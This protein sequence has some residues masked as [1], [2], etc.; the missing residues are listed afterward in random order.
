MSHCSHN[1]HLLQTFLKITFALLLLQ[2]AAPERD[3]EIDTILL[4]YT[5]LKMQNLLETQQ[6]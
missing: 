3:I 5:K 2:Q 4:L 6:C 1:L